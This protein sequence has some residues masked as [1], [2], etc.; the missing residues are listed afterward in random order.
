MKT[1]PAHSG[2]RLFVFL[3]LFFVVAVPNLAAQERQQ[4]KALTLSEALELA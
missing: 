1:T 2:F 3:W 4:S